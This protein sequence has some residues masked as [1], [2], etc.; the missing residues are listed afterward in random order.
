M[1]RRVT[2]PLSRAHPHARYP[3]RVGHHGAFH[4]TLRS[5]PLT[6]RRR[7]SFR[8]TTPQAALWRAAHS[9]PRYAVIH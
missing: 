8:N 7:F 1:A 4:Y 2:P 9:T 3:I 5:S 6:L